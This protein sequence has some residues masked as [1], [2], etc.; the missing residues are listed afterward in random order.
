NVARNQYARFNLRRQNY[1]KHNNEQ[2]FHRNTSA[3][4]AER[5]PS[6]SVKE[7][8]QD[9]S[10]SVEIHGLSSSQL[11]IRCGASNQGCTTVTA[12]KPIRASIANRSND[13]NG[14]FFSRVPECAITDPIAS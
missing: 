4:V 8:T 7:R 10:K 14:P 3:D 1:Q 5:Q 12:R 2:V 13:D 9:C 11:R 6:A